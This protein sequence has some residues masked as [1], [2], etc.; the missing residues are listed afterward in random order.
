MMHE[1]LLQDAAAWP[2]TVCVR[3]SYGCRTHA[4]CRLVYLDAAMERVKT[5]IPGYWVGL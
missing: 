3:R 5:A 4:V 2:N 1:L